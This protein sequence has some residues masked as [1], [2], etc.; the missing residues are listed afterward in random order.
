MIVGQ[1]QSAYIQRLKE[2]ESTYVKNL[3]VKESLVK[4]AHIKIAK[5]QDNKWYITK[6]K[7]KTSE[8]LEA[9]GVNIEAEI[10]SLN[11]E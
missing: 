4:G 2:A 6:P 1:I 3:S 9:M 11:K 7:K 8:L 10:E 5:H